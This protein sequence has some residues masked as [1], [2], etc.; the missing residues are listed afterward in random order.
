[1]GDGSSA[2]AAGEQADSGSGGG[3]GSGGPSDQA[4][5][6]VC[7][8]I[9]D[10]GGLDLVDCFPRCKGQ[11][12]SE[13]CMQ[14]I[15][16]SPCSEVTKSQDEN[17]SWLDACFAPCDGGASCEGDKQRRCRN[18]REILENCEWICFPSW[19]GYCGVSYQGAVTKD[20][21]PAC[22]CY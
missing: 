6:E 19:S 22:W 5:V 12:W 4:C 11:N 17:P 13:P 10:C 3:G 2:G 14:A 16:D 7:Q 20:G 18:G 9:E 15:S 21:L 8:T 1:V